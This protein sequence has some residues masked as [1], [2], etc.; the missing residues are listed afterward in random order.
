[1]PLDFSHIPGALDEF[2]YELWEIHALIFY[3]DDPNE[4]IGE[5]LE[6]IA[7]CDI[8]HKLMS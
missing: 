3:G 7:W 6:F 5:F 4:F 8:V 2:Q 1:M